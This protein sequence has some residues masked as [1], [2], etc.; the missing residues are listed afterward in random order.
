MEWGGINL[1]NFYNIAFEKLKIWRSHDQEVF[2]L[3]EAQEA[4]FLQQRSKGNPI[5]RKKT[6]KTNVQ[7]NEEV[8][9]F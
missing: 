5:L 6:V 4:D 1:N 7:N 2:K 3:I 8:G 9:F